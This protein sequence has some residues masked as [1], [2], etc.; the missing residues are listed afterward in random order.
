MIDKMRSE[1]SVER[2][3]RAL[4]IGASGYYACCQRGRKAG[5]RAQQNE[6]LTN[7]IIREFEASKKRYGSPRVYEALRKRGF[8]VGENRVARLMRHEEIRAERRKRARPRSKSCK[9]EE[10]LARNHLKDRKK[11]PIGVDEVWVSDTTYVTGIGGWL[12]LA[13]VLDLGTRT[14]AGYE[15]GSKNNADLV[16]RALKKAYRIRQ[17]KKGLL[18]HSDQ[19]ST[20]ASNAY[21]K[22]LKEYQMIPSM[23]RRG[24]C[25]DNAEQESFFSTLK[26]ETPIDSRPLHRE[27]IER[28]LIQYIDGFYNRTRIHTSLNGLSPL[29][30]EV[31]LKQ[32]ASDAPK[33]IHPNVRN[34][35]ST[36]NKT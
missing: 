11:K 24:Q 27:E 31:K 2:L 32:I 28:Q 7:E 15:L 19:G 23:S 1:H 14:V 18:H 17:P 33:T 36:R 20:Y 5:P 21:Q 22:L 10:A 13:T 8:Q 16:C 35:K 6:A 29:E 34:T 26:M 30:Y 12:Y 9:P 4:G 3:C 25:G